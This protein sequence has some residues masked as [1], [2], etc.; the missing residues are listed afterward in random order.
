MTVIGRSVMLIDTELPLTMLK[1]D[2]APTSTFLLSSCNHS[3]N[4][5]T[6]SFLN[7]TFYHFLVELHLS[8]GAIISHGSCTNFSL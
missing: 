3:L 2:P 6:K 5:D 8:L 7:F 4:T 1:L